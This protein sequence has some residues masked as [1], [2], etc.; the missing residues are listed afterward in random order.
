[1]S[2]DDL[3]DMDE[4][5]VVP[6]DRPTMADLKQFLRQQDYTEYSPQAMIMMFTL[7]RQYDPR[8]PPER[9]VGY[10]QM[11]LS[12]LSDG[13]SAG[14]TTQRKVFTIGSSDTI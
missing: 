7:L 10:C 2:D 13:G 14:N 1:M 12:H 5:R 8:S 9:Q 11:Q 3:V 6:M 4:E